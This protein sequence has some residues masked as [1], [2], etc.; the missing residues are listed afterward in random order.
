MNT[1]GYIQ[2]KANVYKIR[3]TRSRLDELAPPIANIK[4]IKFLIQYNWDE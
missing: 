3:P 1:F 2:N 4:I